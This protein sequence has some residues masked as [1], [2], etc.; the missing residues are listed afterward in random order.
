MLRARP[1]MRR[2]ARL[3]RLVPGV[4]A[5]FVAS[6]MPRGAWLVHHHAGGGQAHVHLHGVETADQ[7]GGDRSGP[8]EH[9]HLHAHAAVPRHRDEHRHPHEHHP[10]QDLDQWHHHDH[11]LDHAHHRDHDHGVDAAGASG[12]NDL[13][14]AD[15]ARATPGLAPAT[16]Y[17]SDHVHWRQPFQLAAVLVVARTVRA[18]A[19]RTVA[20]ALPSQTAHV[21]AVPAPA[22][23]PPD[24]S[25]SS[26]R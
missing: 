1:S 24:S 25:P 5:L 3:Q 8:G 15:P 18:E 20:V 17:P 11:D 14:A 7:D 4:L 23:A 10:A 26:D 12:P 22:R 19:V 21:A 16:L 2:C 13:N 6:T 9:G